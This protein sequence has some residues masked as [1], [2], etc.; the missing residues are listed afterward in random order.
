MCYWILVEN[1]NYIA[2]STVIP[3]PSEDLSLTLLKEIINAFTMN[4]H[5]VIGDHKKVII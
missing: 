1:G 3:I 2:R 5:D 4:V